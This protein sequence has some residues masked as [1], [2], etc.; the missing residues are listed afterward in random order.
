MNDLNVDWRR[1]DVGDGNVKVVAELREGLRDGPGEDDDSESVLDIGT[2]VIVCIAS[3][4]C[5]A[6]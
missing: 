4:A 1:E 2:N 5:A 3:N 6:V